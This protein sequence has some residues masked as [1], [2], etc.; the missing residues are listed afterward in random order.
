MQT[1][2]YYSLYFCECIDCNEM[3]PTNFILLYSLDLWMFQ[4][5]FDKDCSKFWVNNSI[6][7]GKNKTMH[8]FKEKYQPLEWYF[9]FFK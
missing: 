6:K 1:S 5:Q 3:K 4:R 2:F 9:N 8:V 7:Q